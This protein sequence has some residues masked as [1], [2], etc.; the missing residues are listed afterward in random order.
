MGHVDASAP[1]HLLSFLSSLLQ[2]TSHLI[3]HCSP[4]TFLNL[5]CLCVPPAPPSSV[6]LVVV[7]LCSGPLNGFLMKRRSSA[8]DAT[9]GERRRRRSVR[10][11][12]CLRSAKHS[13]LRHFFSRQS[14]VVVVAISTNIRW[15]EGVRRGGTCFCERQRKSGGEG[16]F[17]VVEV[18][19]E[20]GGG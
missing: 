4:M 5:L 16:G 18:R 17:S 8:L 10:R 20:T 3:S 11:P 1:P 19:R 13:G 14:G 9:S 12:G 7:S 2:N 6:C 15:C